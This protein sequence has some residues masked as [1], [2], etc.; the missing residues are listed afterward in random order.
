M[1]AIASEISLHLNKS[2]QADNGCLPY[3]VFFTGVDTELG[4]TQDV[5]DSRVY[6]M[7][8]PS[9]FSFFFSSEISFPYGLAFEPHIMGMDT[10]DVLPAWFHVGSIM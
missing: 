8:Y 5:D 1:T 4:G 3:P 7:I 9:S 6:V 10:R 2:F